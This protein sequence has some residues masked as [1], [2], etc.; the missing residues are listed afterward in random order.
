MKKQI[1]HKYNNQETMKMFYEL[2]TPN[3]ITRD[4]LSAFYN[5]LD[6]SF[7]FDEFTALEL[8]FGFK[9]AIDF[10]LY[11]AMLTPIAPFDFPT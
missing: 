4:S 3:T 2:A 5:K 6:L 8:K 11:M 10:K 1:F 7:T 9:D